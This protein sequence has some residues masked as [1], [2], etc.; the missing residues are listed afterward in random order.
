MLNHVALSGGRISGSLSA[1]NMGMS[2]FMVGILL[3]MF[4]VLPMLLSVTAGRFVDRIGVERP[5]VAGN[6]L[7]VIGVL[8][9]FAWPTPATLLIAACLMGVGFMFHQVC[10]Q[11]QLGYGSSEERMRNFSWLSLSQAVSGLS[12][13]LAAGLSIDYL[14]YRF[15]FGPIALAPIIA[16]ALTWRLRGLLL[17]PAPK[18]DSGDNAPRRARDLL[19]IPALRRVLLANMLVSGAWDTHQFLIPLYGEAIGLSA[20]T[21]GIVLASFAA[22]TF[23]IRLGLPYIQRR[24]LPW[25]LVRSAMVGAGI[26][27]LL[28][29]FFSTLEPMIAVAFLLGL[30][31]GCVQPS[32][33]ALLHQYTPD[34]RIAEAFGIRIALIN[35]SQVSLPLAC[36]ALATLTGLAPLFWTYALALAGGAWVNRRTGRPTKALSDA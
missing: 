7:M 25:T 33:L 16:L 17:P 34:G 23:V 32:V 26:S 1:L 4:A 24:V 15:A 35:S 21:I 19:A 11:R 3:A 14:G 30:S 8:L 2:S 13:P 29:P 20:T 28:Y 31:L 9:C 18:S 10:A 27:F 5:L 36:G 6:V 22:A 12:G